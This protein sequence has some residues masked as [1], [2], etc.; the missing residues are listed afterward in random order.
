M[1]VQ[2]REYLF[3][4]LKGIFKNVKN[5]IKFARKKTATNKSNSKI[6]KHTIKKYIFKRKHKSV[7]IAM[8][9]TI[10]IITVAGTRWFT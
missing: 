4:K 7:M 1:D 6:S 8:S 2:K 3:A 9:N 10:A 5:V